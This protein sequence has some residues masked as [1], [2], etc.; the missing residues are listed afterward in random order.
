[1]TEPEPVLMALHEQHYKLMWQGL[2][3]HEFRRRYMEGRPT[4]W[5]V[6]LTA[7]LARLTAVIDLGPP[8]V[9]VPDR[10]AAIAE[11]AQA[12]NGARV[13]E[14]L[15]GLDRGFAIPI[16]RVSEYPGLSIEDLRNELGSFQPPQAYIRLRRH[17]HL[18]AVCEKFAAE[19]PTRQL[20]VRHR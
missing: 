18:L 13:L 10:I 5:F 7:P 20:S 16:L 14:Y 1:M 15:K 6:Y 4:R 19:T 12:G 2:K 3:K 17:E 8:V 9:D 11:Q